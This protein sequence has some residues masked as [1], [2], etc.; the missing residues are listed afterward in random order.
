MTEKAINEMPVKTWNWL[1]MNGALI[2]VPD[3]ISK[4]APIEIHADN[5][6]M[7]PSELPFEFENGA[8]TEGTVDISVD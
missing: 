2:D 4:G 6:G 3:G 5:D 8:N 1:K 7:K